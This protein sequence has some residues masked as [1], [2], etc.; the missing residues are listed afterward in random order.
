M[1]YMQEYKIRMARNGLNFNES[2]MSN[3]QN[4]RSSSFL[5]APNVRDI[6]HNGISKKV[7]VN[8]AKSADGLSRIKD[9]YLKIMFQ[10]YNEEVEVG[11]YIQ[12]GDK[13]YIVFSINKINKSS[14]LMEFCNSLFKWNDRSGNGYSY[15]GCSVADTFYNTG[16]T[17]TKYNSYGSGKLTVW[18]PYNIDTAT[19]QR[20]TRFVVDNK[21]Y[22]TTDVDY[23]SYVY[24]GKGII[25]LVMEEELQQGLD[26][27]KDNTAHNIVE[28]AIDIIGLPQQL[29]VGQE[30]K[31]KARVTLDG[32]E[33]EEVVKWH[34]SSG[35]I[36][37]RNGFYYLKVETVGEVKITAL[38]T[39]KEV[40][41]EKILKAVENNNVKY[42]LHSNDDYIVRKNSQKEFAILRF[43]N[44]V[45]NNDTTYKI[46][47][48]EIEGVANSQYEVKI[49]ENIITVKNKNISLNKTLVLIIKD[50]VKNTSFTREIQFKGLF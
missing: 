47:W 25:T 15:W 6:I 11:D 49:D 23:A 50:E 1:D 29:L 19:I 8:Q 37:H 32:K 5:N 45:E 27:V 3:S 39:S 40:K 42:V 9:D 26:D 10:C 46:K 13:N 17:H 22:R 21:V 12:L 28:Y 38:M 48:K 18:I 31:L 44:G 35:T 16:V 36:S 2:L 43:V 4:F 14:A 7:R 20:N 34:S 24:N 30:Y 41:S 33:V